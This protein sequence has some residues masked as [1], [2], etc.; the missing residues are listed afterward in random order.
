MTIGAFVRSAAAAATL[1]IAASAALG[2]EI[3]KFSLFDGETV[4]GRLSL[5]AAQARIR[6]LV[7]YVHGTGPSTY[8]N[9][10]G[11]KQF[12]FNYFDNFADEFNKRGIAFFSYNKRGMGL[13]EEPPFETVDRVK[14]KRVVPSVEVRDLATFIK[15]LRSDK[16]LKKARVILLGWSEGTILAAMAA[17]DR[18]NKI[19]ALFLAGYVHDN[20]TEVIKW[21]NSGG[22]A[23]VNLRAAF[24][25]D[26]DGTISRAEYESTE[27]NVADYRTR[28]LQNA[29]FEQIDIDK[30]DAITIKDFGLIQAPRYKLITDAIAKGDEEW[31]WKNYFRVS[32]D[33]LREHD[34]LEANKTRLLRLKLP[35]YVFHGESDA[36]CRSDA[37]AELRAS[38]DRAGKRNLSEFVFPGHDHD[39]NFAEW[40]TKKTISPGITR[41]FETADQLNR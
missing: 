9:R 39:L 6:T 29:K 27:K 23:M 5:P 3:I 35:I 8:L 34:K 41:M 17:E 31:I 16:R 20:M 4:E 18:R 25:A 1:L 21:Q 15:S 38:F 19:H 36:N 40:I 37:V 22:S 11:T 28:R 33:W 10:R 13:A 30:D 2:G 24:D 32:I 7:I 12:A 26:K 14:F